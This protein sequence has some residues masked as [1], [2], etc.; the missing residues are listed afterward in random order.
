MAATQA[1]SFKVV[2]AG[3][4][5]VVT[6]APAGRPDLAGPL[7]RPARPVAPGRVGTVAS[8]QV[9]RP[10]MASPLLA[11]KV[12]LVG[13]LAAVGLT[14]SAAQ[15]VGMGQVDPATDYVAGDPAWAHVT[16]SR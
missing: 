12:A 9:A 3:A 11:L 5:R 14:V 16:V 10:P 6:V 15:F 13:I 7:A 4:R 2:H 8:C 1:V